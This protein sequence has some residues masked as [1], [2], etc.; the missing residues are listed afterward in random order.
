M[1]ISYVGLF[2]KC[3]I[4]IDLPLLMYTCINT[5]ST[6]AFKNLLQSTI[7]PEIKPAWD[8]DIQFSQKPWGLYTIHVFNE[9]KEE[10]D[11]RYY[12]VI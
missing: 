5:H 8:K 2:R 7:A 10:S 6:I 1:Q 12:V 4:Q 11:Q 9:P 3:M